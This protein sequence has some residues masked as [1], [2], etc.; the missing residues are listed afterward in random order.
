[1][2]LSLNTATVKRAS[3]AEAARLCV[4]NGIT[5]IG[6]WRDVVADAGGAGA[7][8]K[9]VDDHGLTVTSLCRGGFFPAATAALR[10]CGRNPGGVAS[11]TTS[12]PLSITF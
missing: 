1:M 12:T 6:P 5:G 10:C 3:L 2:K 11:S 8:R 7:A 4:A 9:L